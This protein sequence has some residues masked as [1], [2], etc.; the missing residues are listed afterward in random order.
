MLEIL[1]RR[2]FLKLN[3]S[4][5]R[6][7]LTDLQE[8]LKRRWRYSIPAESQIHNHMLIPDYQDIKIQD[9]HYSDGFECYQVIKIGSLHLTIVWHDL[10]SRLIA[11]KLWYDN[12]RLVIYSCRGR[13]ARGNPQQTLNDKGVID[14]G[15]SRHMT[16]NISF[17][18]DFKE[19]NGGY[20]AFRGN[21]KGG[22]ISGKGTGLAA[23]RDTSLDLVKT[24]I[25]TAFLFE[26][27]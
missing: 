15:C 19:I 17:F 26:W 22:K 21:P 12:S 13:Y 11:L 27:G 9:F 1:S 4:D 23:L 16:K 14:S 8:T 25:G 2:F 6:S 18:S 5:H 20:V 7:I 3:L 24:A 10:I